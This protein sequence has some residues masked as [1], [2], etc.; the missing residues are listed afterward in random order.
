[1]TKS[2]YAQDG[3]DV[4]EE[5]GFSSYAGGVCKESYTNSKFV[6]VHDLS[7]GSFRGPRPITFKNLPEG[8][9]VEASSDGIGTKGILI[10]AANMHHTAA[11]DLMAMVSSDITRY[12]GLPLVIVNILDVVTVGEAGDDISKT[13]KGLVDG[14]GKAAK[15]LNAVILKGETAQM[16]VCLGSEITDSPTKFNWGATMLGAYH[17]DKMVTGDSVAEGQVIL[18]LKEN[19]FR[20]NGI[21]SVR[22]ALAMNYGEKWFENPDAQQDIKKAAEPSVLYD[23][24]I[25]TLHGWFSGDFKEEV[26][27]HAIIHL[28]GGAIR[29][30]LAKD[31]L[32]SRG[33]SAELPNLWE[34]PEIMRTCAGWRGMQDEEFYESWNG[35]QGMFLIVDEKDVDYSIQRA[36]DFGI[37]VQAAGKITQQ[38]SPSVTITSK[39]SGE[40]VVYQKS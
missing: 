14:L 29:E 40:T 20:C 22:K 27:L 10:D 7:G 4:E 8:Y 34:P 32:F 16:G 33:L 28:S 37:E 3:V 38:E 30:K 17:K 1:M 31:L 5:A 19:G 18:A 25:N 2:L 9:M 23:Q 36:K 11:Y 26:K 35:G 24:Y 21:S 13:Y 12:G 39:L 6:E 15:D